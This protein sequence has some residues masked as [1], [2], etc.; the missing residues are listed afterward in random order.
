MKAILI[1]PFAKTITET[2][3]EE[4][5]TAIY[6]VLSTDK[7]KVGTFQII[8]LDIVAR[9]RNTLYIDDNGLLHTPPVKH[10]FELHGYAQPLAGRGLILGTTRGGDSRSTTYELAR[11]RTAITFRDDI[12]H[13][14]FEHATGKIDHPVLGPGT[15]VF[16]QRAIFEDK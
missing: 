11:V 8:E 16:A 9:V 14:G 12:R 3:I 1:D 10:F 7:V 13:A 4:G 5:I 15:T 6:A 2:E